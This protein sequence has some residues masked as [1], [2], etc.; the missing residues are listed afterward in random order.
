MVRKKNRRI[1]GTTGKRPVN[2]LKEENLK[3]LPSLEKYQRFL[4]EERKVYKDALLSFDGVR[5][6]VPWQYSGKKVVVR[7][8][9]D[10]IE[11]LYDGKVIATHEKHYRLRTTVFL[12][13][14]YKGVKEVEGMLYPRPR[15]IKIFSLEVEKRSLEVYER[16]LEVGRVR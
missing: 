12:K 5:Y 13:D 6:G 3:P 7:D 1:H 16:F 11:I 15:E 4:E 9:N 14:Q 2:R 10:K 8:K